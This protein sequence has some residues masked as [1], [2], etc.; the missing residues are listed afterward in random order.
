MKEL[1]ETDGSPSPRG[2][3]SQGIRAADLVFVA[4]QGPRDPATGRVA[5]GIEAQTHQAL[6]N[7]ASIL[8]AGHAT[9]DDVVKVTVH[10]ADLA[11]F[12]AFDLAYTEHFRR[13]YPVRTTVGSLLPGILLEIDV[14]AVVRGDAIARPA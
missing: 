2:A 10:L 6:R 11:D 9:M 3:Y 12:E 13:P 4:G 14:I 7:V 8:E 5:D 1:I